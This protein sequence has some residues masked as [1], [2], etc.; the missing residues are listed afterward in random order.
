MRGAL[1]ACSF[2]PVIGALERPQLGG[3]GIRVPAILLPGRRAHGRLQGRIGRLARPR[4]VLLLAL[5]LAARVH[6]PA[7]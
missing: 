7:R 4:Q 5:I 1:L 6:P 2:H 3:G